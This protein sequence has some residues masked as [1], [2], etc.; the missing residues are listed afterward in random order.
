MKVC[1]LALTGL[2]NTVLEALRNI[3]H[4]QDLLVFTRREK[5]DFPYYPC[6]H[7]TELCS[8]ARISCFDDRKL[9]SKETYGQIMDFLPDLILVATF[10]Q[11]ISPAIINIPRLGAVNIHPSLLP[12]YRGPCPTHWAVIH[13]EKETGITFHQVT[14]GYDL[15]DILYQRRIGIDA[16]TDGELRQKLAQLASECLEGFLGAYLHGK[17]KPS[18]QDPDQGSYFPKITSKEGISLLKSG[19]FPKDCLIRGLYPYPGLD[20]LNKEI[21]GLQE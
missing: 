3:V 10:D 7:L 11:K 20:I 15:G 9:T 14:E 18:A 2:G 1:L 21:D 12:K 4:E 13:G 16:L 6:V 8:K 17:L 5:G 19:H